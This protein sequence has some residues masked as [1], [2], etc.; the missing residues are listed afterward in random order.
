M[1]VFAFFTYLLTY[2]PGVPGCALLPLGALSARLPHASLPAE[3][4]TR[5]ARC[6]Q[7]D[8]QVVVLLVG[9]TAHHRL[10]GLVLGEGAQRIDGLGR[11]R[12]CYEGLRAEQ[13]GK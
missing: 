12:R 3:P 1:T 5:Q 13:A 8:A 9:G 7:L 4:C 6:L 10:E 11:Q 2:M